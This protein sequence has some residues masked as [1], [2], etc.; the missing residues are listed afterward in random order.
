MLHNL[1]PRIVI[2]GRDW[3]SWWHAHREQVPVLLGAEIEREVARLQLVKDQIRA[4]DAAT[5]QALSEGRQPL[6]AHLVRLRAIWTKGRLGAGQGGLRLA[7]LHQPARTGRQLG[8]YAYAAPYA[9]GNSE[10]EQGIGKAGNRRVRTLLV[11]QAWNWLRLQPDGAL[12]E[13]FN[14]RFAARASACAAWH[15]RAGQALG[16]RLV[17]LP[18]RRRDSG[19]CALE[20]DRGS[21]VNATLRR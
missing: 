11:E 2:G 9:S 10:I 21:S 20:A 5:R 8:P 14:R 7:P 19:R 16:N 18:A 4:I 13:W 15:R 17:A 12:S 3:T 6:A 1:R